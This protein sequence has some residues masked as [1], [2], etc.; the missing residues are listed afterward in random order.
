L[1]LGNEKCLEAH[2]PEKAVF[3]GFPAVIAGF[4]QPLEELACGKNSV[5][6]PGGREL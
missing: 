1:R 4:G 2:R 6:I 3:C 5:I